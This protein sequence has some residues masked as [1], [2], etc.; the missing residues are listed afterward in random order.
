MPSCFVE[1]NANPELKFQEAQE[2]DETRS[3]LIDVA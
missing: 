3:R 2:E 1:S